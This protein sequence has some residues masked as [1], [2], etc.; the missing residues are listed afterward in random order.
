MKI[1]ENDEIV[2]KLDIYS[3]FEGKK[4][5]NGSTFTRKTQSYKIDI[6][7][8]VLFIEGFIKKK[9]IKRRKEGKGRSPNAYIA[10]SNMKKLE[11]WL[12]KKLI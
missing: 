1:I 12:Q 11:K 6:V 7:F 2:S 5:P 3:I 8:S 10:V 9:G 4:L